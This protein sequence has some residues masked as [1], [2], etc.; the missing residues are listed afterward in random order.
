MGLAP[1]VNWFSAWNKSTSARA[2]STINRT[3]RFPSTAAYSAI[4]DKGLL[5]ASNSTSEMAI[6]E[7]TGASS[8]TARSTS[9]R[10]FA[11]SRSPVTNER[12][13]VSTP[14]SK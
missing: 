14:A 10:F 12:N 9:S 7:R 4:L 5:A 6:Q 2:P 13:A 3:T 1:H 11:G 8:R